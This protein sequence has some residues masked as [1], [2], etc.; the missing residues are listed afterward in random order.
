MS[1]EQEPRLFDLMAMPS[2]GIVCLLR[3]IM[4]FAG[5]AAI[6]IGIHLRN[7]AGFGY[8][9]AFVLVCLGLCVVVTTWYANGQRN[10]AKW[11]REYWQRNVRGYW[12]FFH[13]CTNE[14]VVF[15]WGTTWRSYERACERCRQPDS[16]IFF[17]DIQV[18]LGGWGKRGCIA[19]PPDYSL[20]R[21]LF[22]RTPW[23]VALIQT[24]TGVLCRITDP[25]G[26]ARIYGLTEALTIMTGRVNA[27]GEKTWADIDRATA[28]TH[29]ERN[30][31]ARKQQE[32][33]GAVRGVVETFD[34]R[35]R[36]P[37]SK[38]GDPFRSHLVALYHLFVHR[39]QPGFND[40]AESPRARRERERPQSR[41]P[42]V[43]QRIVAVDGQPWV[44]ES[45]EV[46]PSTSG[47]APNP[48]LRPNEHPFTA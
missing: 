9:G 35:T 38:E 18:P 36:L 33:L 43:K 44:P 21:F 8:F 40:Y 31:L 30:S 32:T 37:Y 27:G 13:L 24:D 10:L 39:G 17:M 3:I 4:I 34:S 41:Q 1:T 19:L 22:C 11:F 20:N 7:E 28:H 47:A 6:P 26:R 48:L 42:A 23:R 14:E 5:I 29:A 15:L 25:K 45:G 16:E 12:A 2:G 46:P